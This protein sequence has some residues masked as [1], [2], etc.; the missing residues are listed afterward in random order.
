M[1]DKSARWR[2]IFKVSA[3]VL[4]C[5]LAL[6]S[7]PRSGTGFSQLQVSGTGALDGSTLQINLFANTVLN[8]GESFDIFH[9]AGGLSGVFASITGSGASYFTEQ[10][11]VT[12]VFLVATQALAPSSV[13]LPPTLLLLAPGLVGLVGRRWLVTRRK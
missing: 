2:E 6:C 13:P 9:A 3:L 5:V 1:R 12:D 8:V 7:A 10:Y 4:L 11:T